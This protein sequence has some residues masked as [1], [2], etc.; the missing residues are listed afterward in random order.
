[1]DRLDEIFDSNN[2]VMRFLALLVDLVVLNL[3]S[4]ICALP[5]V[6]AGGSLA[7]MNYETLHLHRRD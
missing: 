6:T 2:P 5:L 1:M 7:A 3:M 4:V